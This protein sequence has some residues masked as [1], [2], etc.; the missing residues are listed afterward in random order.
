MTSR[1]L[2]GSNFIKYSCSLENRREI[3]QGQ[4]PYDKV[5]EN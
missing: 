5:R 1:F 2:Y 3:P 4:T